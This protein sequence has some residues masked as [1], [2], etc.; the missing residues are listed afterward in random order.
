[1]SDS[2]TSDPVLS[3][4]VLSDASKPQTYTHG[5]HESVLRSHRWRTV[6]NSAA[7]LVPYL[8][9]G[10]C[11]LDVGCGPGTISLDLA[12]RIL[13]GSVVG[14]DSSPEAIEAARQAAAADSKETSNHVSF[15]VGD[16]YSLDFEDNS[17]DI[18][19]A[20]QVLQHLADPVSA[21]REWKRVVKPG[22]FI[23]AR[24]ADYG[25]MRWFPADARIDEWQRLY[26][27]AARQ[28]SGEPDAGRQLLAWAN[29]VGF[30]RVDATASVWCFANETDRRWWGTMWSDRITT[31]ALASQLI[32][33]NVAT[34]QTL[35]DVATGFQHYAANPDGW[36]SVLHGEIICWK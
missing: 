15:A 21:L 8:Q 31:S 33:M 9:Q 28:N 16:A 26:Q 6:E 4:P 12:Q 34:T 10:H 13:P 23:A 32:E 29:E 27:L 19:H 30:E 22:G 35:S 5:H 20:H 7:Y 3:D 11:V 25:A 1:M 17:F 18:V 24:D 2:I 14:I 36:F